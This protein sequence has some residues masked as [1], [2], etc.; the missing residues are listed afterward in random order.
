[1]LGVP[2]SVLYAEGKVGLISL[3]FAE[4]PAAATKRIF[5]LAARMIASCKAW[6]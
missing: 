2:T 6:E 5:C 3:F 1:M 4:F